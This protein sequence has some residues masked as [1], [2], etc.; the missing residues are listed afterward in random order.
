MDNIHPPRAMDF[1]AH[2]NLAEG[3][4]SFKERFNL[5]LRASGANEKAESTQVAILVHTMG[6][7]AIE[8][9]RTFV[10]ENPADKD[11]LTAVQDKFES[12][13]TPKTNVVL[14]RFNFNKATQSEGE[15]IESYLTRLR[16]LAKTCEYGDLTDSLIRDRIVVT[17]LDKGLKERLL[18]EPDL[19]LTKCID[20]CKTAEATRR[21]IDQLQQDIP[22]IAT[23]SSD[24]AGGDK[25]PKNKQSSSGGWTRRPRMVCRFCGTN[26]P[27]RK[28]PAYGKTCSN[29]GKKNHFRV[30][31]E[32]QKGVHSVELASQLED[33]QEDIEG[34]DLFFNVVDID[35]VRNV[36]D[37]WTCLIHVGH[38][39]IPFKLDTG[40]QANVI[41]ESDF[42]TLRGTKI[43]EAKEILRGYTGDRLQV[44]GKCVLPVNFSGR[45]CKALFYVVRGTQQSLLGLDLC[46]RLNLI[47]L[48][49]KTVEVN[50]TNYTSVSVIKQDVSTGYDWIDSDYKDVFEGLGCLPGRYHIEVDP[51]VKPVVYPC[52]KVPFQLQDKF[53]EELGKMED[54]GVIVK[55]NEPTEWVN[56]FVIAEKPNGK[57]RVCLDPRALNRAIK[58]ERFDLPTREE[59]QSKF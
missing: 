46:K 3:W 42:R 14:E 33:L 43:H 55:V 5:Y 44:A 9:Y 17:I 32:R 8:I 53:K 15:Q 41:T 59:V 40:A 2:A 25:G 54:L 28:C 1:T 4:R 20:L 19:S 50:P 35:D 49:C 24:R 11:K 34:K 57:L 22:Q 58:R 12:Y 51:A 27:P 26:H 21:H 56:A 31:C 18:R 23:V 13:F 38:N 37:N 39:I 10:F 52:R 47:Q 16:L 29:C 45:T 36:P 6:E 7:Q 30:V 48:N